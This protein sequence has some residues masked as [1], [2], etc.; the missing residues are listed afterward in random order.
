MSGCCWNLGRKGYSPVTAV[1]DLFLVDFPCAIVRC[2]CVDRNGLLIPLCVKYAF[3]IDAAKG[4]RAKEIALRL[5]LVW[6]QALRLYEF[7]LRLGFRDGKT[8]LA[9]TFNMHGDCGADI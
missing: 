1:H 2:R 8:V 3:L 5:E 4:A 9:Q 7:G 6:A